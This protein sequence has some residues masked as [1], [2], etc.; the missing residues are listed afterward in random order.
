M[1]K[2]IVLALGLLL[3]TSCKLKEEI[4]FNEN[5]SGTYNLVVDMSGMMSMAK[6]MDKSADSTKTKKEPIVKDSIFKLSDLLIEKKDSI[7]KLSKEERESLEKLK[8]LSVKIH[9][10]ETKGE[11]EMA[12]V[13]SFKNPKDLDNIMNKLSE[14]DKLSK[15]GKSNPMDEMGDAFPKTEVRYKFNKRSFQRIST[16][17]KS[18]EDE[19]EETEKK[20]NKLEQ[21]SQMFQF[22][23]VYHFPRRIKSIN[24]KDALLS[25]DGKTVHIN[26][27]LSKL[28]SPE[29]MNLKVEFE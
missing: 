22:E 8:D 17:V 4:T 13:F 3:F 2:F 24:Y 6:G 11:M 27:P 23:L 10:D 25:S 21:F 18:E 15:K 26:V 5:G 16:K 29:L 9:M 12:Y 20:D 14:V 28:E 7:A 1:K 19:K